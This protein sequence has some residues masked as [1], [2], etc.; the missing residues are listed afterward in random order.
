MFLEREIISKERKMLSSNVSEQVD[1]YGSLFRDEY[2][3][4]MPFFWKVN[5]SLV[6]DLKTIKATRQVCNFK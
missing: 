5:P 2:R 1:F 3:K 6:S 4:K